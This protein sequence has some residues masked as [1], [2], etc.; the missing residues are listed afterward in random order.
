ML[1]PVGHGGVRRPAPR[2]RTLESMVTN[3]N[4]RQHR[5]IVRHLRPACAFP[6]PES[7]QEGN[8][9]SGVLV[10]PAGK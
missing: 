3:F 10:S 7:G 8:V 2:A 1:H 6:L 4:I 5:R 9:R